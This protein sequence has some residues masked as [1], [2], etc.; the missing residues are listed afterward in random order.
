MQIST[1]SAG[2]YIQYIDRSP[3][4]VKRQRDRDR[5]ARN[6]KSDEDRQLEEFEEARARELALLGLFAIHFDTFFA[7]IYVIFSIRHVLYL[8]SD[9]HI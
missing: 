5:W 4:A 9:I 1:V 6:E 3:E 8:I 2:W 7:S